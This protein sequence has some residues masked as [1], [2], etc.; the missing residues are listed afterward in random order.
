LNSDMNSENTSISSNKSL[1]GDNISMN[2]NSNTEHSNKPSDIDHSITNT[3]ITL[4]RNCEP[5]LIS[6]SYEELDLMNMLTI[7]EKEEEENIV[8]LD[9]NL[10]IITIA[11]GN[12]IS[13]LDKIEVYEYLK[14]DQMPTITNSL[15]W[16]KNAQDKYLIIASLACKYLAIPS[17]ATL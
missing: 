8:N 7:F 14:L 17:T 13:K 11:N 3:I 2:L 10:E 16:W 4:T 1:S 6:I 5:L 12:A 15:N 9:N